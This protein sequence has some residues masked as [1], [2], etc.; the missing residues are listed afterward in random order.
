MNWNFQQTDLSGFSPRKKVT[1]KPRLKIEMTGS[2]VDY[3][4]LVR[5]PFEVAHSKSCSR[6][7]FVSNIAM[8]RNALS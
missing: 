3:F 4:L 8:Y 7:R 2:L 1:E 6:S 5:K